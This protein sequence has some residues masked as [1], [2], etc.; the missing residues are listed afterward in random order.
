MVYFNFS[1]VD[2]ATRKQVN[3]GKRV[4]RL[5]SYFRAKLVSPRNRKILFHSSHG[6]PGI[7]NRKI[8]SNGKRPNF[9]HCLGLIDVLSANQHDEI[10][11]CIL[12]Q[13][14]I[15]SIHNRQYSEKFMASKS[16][17]PLQLNFFNRRERECHCNRFRCPIHQRLD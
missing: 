6:I 2:R 5:I 11:A 17:F 9:L 3:K 13:G 12:L 10:F 4:L 7:S 15:A 8:L 14:G 1:V 16:R